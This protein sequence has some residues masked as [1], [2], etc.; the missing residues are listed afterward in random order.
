MSCRPRSLSRYTTASEPFEG[1]VAMTTMTKHEGPNA[2]QAIED[3]PRPNPLLH[4]AS[5]SRLA[6]TP[7]RSGTRSARAHS[8]SSAT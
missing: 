7:N 1:G 3:A 4:R 8:G 2:Y 5:R 6:S